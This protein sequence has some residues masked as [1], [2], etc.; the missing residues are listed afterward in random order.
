M[1]ATKDER[2]DKLR[3]ANRPTRLQ[4]RRRSPSKAPTRKITSTV[5]PVLVKGQA[6]TLTVNGLNSTITSSVNNGP[7]VD[8]KGRPT[9]CSNPADGRPYQG[10]KVTITVVNGDKTTG[11][12]EVKTT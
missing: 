9:N 4:Q 10:D 8:P 7:E 11:T 1:V 3:R 5:P 6:T 2:K 12:F